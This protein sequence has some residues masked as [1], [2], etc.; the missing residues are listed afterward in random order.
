MKK[1]KE[2]FAVAC[3]SLMIIGGLNLS[4]QFLQAHPATVVTQT[5]ATNQTTSQQ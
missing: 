3:A 1:L 5:K 4:S 2:M